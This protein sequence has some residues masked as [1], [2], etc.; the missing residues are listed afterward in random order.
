MNVLS[1]VTYRIEEER[2]RE[3]SVVGGRWSTSTIWNHALH[4][5]RPIRNPPRQPPLEMQ[6]D[7]KA[8]EM[9]SNQ[10]IRFKEHPMIPAGGVDLEWLEDPVVPASEAHQTP[11]V[12][13]VSGTLGPDSQPADIPFHPELS[14]VDNEAIPSQTPVRPRR[15]RR[16][17]LWLQDYVRTVVV[18][19]TWPFNL[20]GTVTY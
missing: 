19:T 9:C 7:Q 6:V 10:F 16:E 15:E 2:R 4:L 17:P 1:D 8:R 14:S 3:G 5:R 12:Q 11:Q 20:V 18:Y 13:E